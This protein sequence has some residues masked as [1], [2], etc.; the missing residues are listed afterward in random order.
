MLFSKKPIL[1]DARG[2]LL[3]RLSATV[4][5]TL[6]Q[7]QRVTVV[8]CEGINISGKYHRQKNRYLS[9]IKKRCNVKPS[10]GP[11]HFRAP[12]KIFYRT[13]RGMI[14]HRTVRGKEAM[15]RLSVFEG[16]PAPYDKKKRVVIPS[17]LRVIRLNPQRKYCELNRISS[18]IG[19]KYSH[20]IETMEQRR[21]TRSSQY[22]SQK[23]NQAKLKAQARKNVAAKT[24]EFDKILAANGYN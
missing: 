17:A 19:W 9:L 18:E 2:H 8:R 4:A 7:G 16:I 3:G 1:I 22:F 13:V 23:K 15:A 10:R 12:R 20:V 6:L 5:K 21:K 14:P 24:A 11:F